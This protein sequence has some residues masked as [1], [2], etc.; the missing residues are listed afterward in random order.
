M[1]ITTRVRRTLKV[2]WTAAAIWALYKIPSLSRRLRGIEF[3]S[4]QLSPTHARAASRILA[5]AL[6]LRG[7]GEVG[8]AQDDLVLLAHGRCV[9]DGASLGRPHALAAAALDHLHDLGDDVAGPFDQDAV[10]GAHVEALDLVEVVER[11]AR[12][13]HAGVPEPGDLLQEHVGIDDDTGPDQVEGLR[14]QDAR[15]DQVQDRGP[16]LDHQGMAR[17]GP[18][19]EAHD[20]VGTLR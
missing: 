8:A 9:A 12:D 14:N 6:D 4:E 1:L 3:T 15:R 10:L 19:L 2:G 18:A 5:L 20:D 11:R 17:V 16:P 7:A 13:G